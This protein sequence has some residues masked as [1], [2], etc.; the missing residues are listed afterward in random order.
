[1]KLKGR[2]ILLILFL[3][4]VGLAFSV[5]T[6]KIRIFIGR[7][8]KIPVEVNID[9]ASPQIFPKIWQGFG[10]GGEETV[11]MIEPVNIEVAALRPSYVRIDHLFDFYNVVSRS[12]NG[13]LSYDWAQ[14]DERVEEILAV[15]AI[16]FL[17]L[18]YL[19][20]VLSSSG[21]IIDSPNSYSEWQELILKTIERYSGKDSKNIPDIY[22]E[23]WNEPDVFGQFKP[24]TYFSLYKHAALAA[25]E[26]QNTNVYKL[27]GP[28]I[29]GVNKT[30]LNNFLGLVA[31]NNLR[32]DFVSWHSYGT[33]PLKIKLESR[34]VDNLANF[35][36]FRQKVEKIVSEWGS[37][38]EMSS[39][40][41]SYFDASHTLATVGESLGSV[42][43]LMAF[44][45]KDG[46][47]PKGNQFWGR[48]GLLT[49]Q[50][51]GIF[52]KPRYGA[53]L[54]L[55]GNLTYF[56]PSTNN[57][58]NVYSVNT[59]DGKGNYLLLITS[60]PFAGANAVKEVSL[61]IQN[62]LP[63]EFRENISFFGPTSFP[64][65]QTNFQSPGNLW[66]KNIS[67][68]PFTTAIIKLERLSPA[69]TK[70]QVSP[71]NP[72][73]F[74]AQ[75]L[76]PLPPLLFPL[77]ESFFE[78]QESGEINFSL[79]PA[80]NGD[81]PEE[82]FFFES[83]ISPSTRLYALKRNDGLASYLDFALE[84]GEIKK[85]VSQDISSWTSDKWYSLSFSWD[86]TKMEMVLKIENEE[87]KDTIG[88]LAKISLGRFISVGSDYEEKKQIN[89]EIDNLAVKIN[90]E[91]LVNETF[92]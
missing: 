69:I 57:L 12:A 24:E 23:V 43:K 17:S 22:Y 86:N 68:N 64:E 36:R 13:S 60:F 72:G 10:Q 82:R 84:Q 4:L 33:N 5:L 67:L 74:A 16:P 11:K 31:A 49:H 29:L 40:H 91:V 80:W 39:N 76:S 47:D 55:N 77:F 18:S 54:T 87:K 85:T 2:E 62:F 25:A 27:G 19:P 63:G 81:D 88:V 20:P 75:I 52:K 53:F 83:R 41:D 6:G 89:A 37:D 9:G 26:A 71:E 32:L 65:S 35:G 8:E 44:E 3:I 45:L 66:Q 1:M 58:H 34:A 73:N 56:L 51:M 70:V 61:S 7:A 15:K 48:W 59:T 42:D 79:K 92:D 78:N 30:W 46:L 28:A 38:S 21:S 50:K 90:G 14:L